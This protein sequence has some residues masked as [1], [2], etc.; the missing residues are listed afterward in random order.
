MFNVVKVESV[1]LKSD[2]F[3][4]SLL[5]DRKILADRDLAAVSRGGFSAVTACRI[6]GR[7]AMGQARSVRWVVMVVASLVTLSSATAQA[8]TD[9]DQVRAVLNGMNGSYNRTDFTEFA[10]HLCDNIRKAAGF[11]AG[12]YASRKSDGP[13]QITINSV[14][15]TGGDAVANVRF[16]AANRAN[17]KTFDVEFRRD[18]TD[19]KAC[20]YDAGQYI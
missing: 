20:R 3:A 17:P 10:T 2:Y 5:E 11:E 16:Q 7:E 6:S 14:Q 18:G 9:E 15:V 4:T 12:W 19:W 13:T 8:A 1:P